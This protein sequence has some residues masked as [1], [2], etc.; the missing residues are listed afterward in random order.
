MPSTSRIPQRSLPIVEFERDL[1]SPR[2]TPRPPVKDPH[3]VHFPAAIPSVNFV[4][5]AIKAAEERIQV[6]F[7]CLRISCS[8]ALLSE[9]LIAEK[10][11]T[12]SLCYLQE[13]NVAW[14][15]ME[16]LMAEK[17]VD[18]GRSSLRRSESAGVLPRPRA[19]VS[20]SLPPRI[21]PT[22]AR[23]YQNC[24]AASSSSSVGEVKKEEKPISLTSSR[25]T[26]PTSPTETLVGDD[27][28]AFVYPDATY[29]LKKVPPFLT[30]N[31][32]KGVTLESE[33]MDVIYKKLSNT[34]ICRICILKRN[35][36]AKDKRAKFHVSSFHVD[37]A[38][39]DL[40][41]HCIVDH[42]HE[43]TQIAGLPPSRLQ[44]MV[45]GF[46]KTDRDEDFMI[47]CTSI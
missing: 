5:N 42:L 19:R 11:R 37:T 2:D 40:Y 12:Q 39:L 1:P 6:E 24:S 15:R 13:R 33:H 25:F 38:S 9:Q 44:E 4:D 46:A 23:T 29:S 22:A 8:Q 27:S 17:T 18:Q 31:P 16:A 36:L 14:A 30:E 3:R 34:H 43:S 10:L 20:R 21:L 28:W 47:D 32:S 26:S 7:S 45:K 35:Q 41:M